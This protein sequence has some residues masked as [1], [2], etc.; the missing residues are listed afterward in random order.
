MTVRTG[1]TEPV[2]PTKNGAKLIEYS[3]LGDTTLVAPPA[4]PPRPRLPP[5]LEE[6]YGDAYWDPEVIVDY[7]P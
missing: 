6:R 1:N 7:T 5:D 4:T 3:E 2:W